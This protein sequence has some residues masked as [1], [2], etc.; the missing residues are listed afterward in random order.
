MPYHLLGID[1]R[2]D[3]YL[4][5]SDAPGERKKMK[6]LVLVAINAD[7]EKKAISGFR[8]DTYKE[9]QKCSEILTDKGI[10]K[11]LEHARKVHAP[12]ANYIHSG[13]GRE[14]QNLDCRIT[15]GILLRLLSDGIPCLPVHDSYIVP[16]QYGG[17]LKQVMTEEYERMLKF[18][19][20][21]K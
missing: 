7:I 15:E 9:V 21:I 20:V 16:R 10:K 6:R 19:P 3:P 11:M 17:L 1:F 13:A 8:G 12:I 4:S 5:L 2:D 14:L 18:A